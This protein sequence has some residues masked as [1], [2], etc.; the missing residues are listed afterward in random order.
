M[1]PIL[2]RPWA[3]I[4][5]SPW[6]FCRGLILSFLPV[7]FIIWA[8]SGPIMP[9]ACSFIFL[10]FPLYLWV[11]DL[12]REGTFCGVHTSYVTSCLRT[13][14]VLFILSEVIFFFSFFWAWAHRSWVPSRYLGQKWPPAGIKPVH[15][16]GAPVFNL[17]SLVWSSGTVNLA[18]GYLRTGDR[19]KALCA[20]GLTVMLRSAFAGVQ[21]VEYRSAAFC[22]R[23][24]VFGRSFFLLTGFHGAHVIGGTRFLVFNWYRLLRFHFHR[25]RNVGWIAAIWYWHFVDLIWVGLWFLVYTWGGWGYFLYWAWPVTEPHYGQW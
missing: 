15:P 9:L 25:G 8:W 6:P 5:P 3:R 13:A 7:G 22:I 20:M 17:A 23:D 24:R 18:N 21:W 14:T 19:N 12:I 16:F 2:K 11:A 4:D 10:V 1:K